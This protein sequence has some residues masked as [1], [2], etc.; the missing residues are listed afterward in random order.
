MLK[1]ISLLVI[2]AMIATNIFTYAATPKTALDYATMEYSGNSARDSFEESLAKD[3]KKFKAR[4]RNQDKHSGPG[5]VETS[6]NYVANPDLT[7]YFE[8]T[9]PPE[10][11][12]DFV[13]VVDPKYG[14]TFRSKRHFKT[15]L[16]EF[17]LIDASFDPVENNSYTNYQFRLKVGKVNQKLTTSYRV[18]L[19]AYNAAGAFVDYTYT[20]FNPD[21]SLVHRELAL[22]L[23][24]N[25]D[26]HVARIEFGLDTSGIDP[27]VVAK[28]NVS[29]FNFGYADLFERLAAA[30]SPFTEEQKAELIATYNKKFDADLKEAEKDVAIVNEIHEVVE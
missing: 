19:K 28:N 17:D 24:K 25:N 26:R 4:Q 22:K 27:A 18:F 13:E 15:N 20:F 5:A 30:D 16:G 12:G 23:F 1:K 8:T 14:I 7:E 9:A 6:G 29:F 10:Y 2:A 11:Q 3:Q 21:V